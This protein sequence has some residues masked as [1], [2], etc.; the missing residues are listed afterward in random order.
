MLMTSSATQRQLADRPECCIIRQ[1]PSIIEPVL[2]SHEDHVLF[3]PSFL[4]VE[5]DALN[6]VMAAG[7]RL[8]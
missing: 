7:R 4:L 5:H 1:E 3:H 8:Y 2:T 6:D